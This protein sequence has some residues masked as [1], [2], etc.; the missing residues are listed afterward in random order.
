MPWTRRTVLGCT[1]RDKKE[2]TDSNKEGRT[3][4]NLEEHTDSNHEVRS[5]HEGQERR[6][7]ESEGRRDREMGDAGIV[8]TRDS[9]TCWPPIS[10]REPFVS[11]SFGISGTTILQ[12]LRTG[13]DRLS[14]R[15]MISI[16]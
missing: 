16:Y 11:Q 4:I 5:E 12:A 2:R 15:I 9:G 8:R 3:D 14:G 6:D 1:E 10:S 13:V 7:R